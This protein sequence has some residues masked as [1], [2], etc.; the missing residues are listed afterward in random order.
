MSRARSDDLH[1]L[2]SPHA[3]PASNHSN[4]VALF[5]E[6]YHDDFATSRVFWFLK[7]VSRSS[8]SPPEFAWHALCIGIRFVC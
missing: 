2:F 3:N 7:G 8:F 6:Q 1:R 4:D 5:S